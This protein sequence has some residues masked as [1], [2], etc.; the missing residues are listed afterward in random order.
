MYFRTYKS[1]LGLTYVSLQFPF[2]PSKAQREY[3]LELCARHWKLRIWLY[4][5]KK[6]LM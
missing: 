1:I 5:L 3:F 6:S 2:T 4:L